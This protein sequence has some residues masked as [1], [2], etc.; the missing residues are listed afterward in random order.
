MVT[1]YQE[2]CQEEVPEMVH[3][4]MNLKAQVGLLLELHWKGNTSVTDETRNAGIL[5]QNF[6]SKSSNRLETGK[7]QVLVVNIL[8]TSLLLDPVDGPLSSLL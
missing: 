6:P 2:V 1:V 5:L 7:V 4:S 8:V 3:C